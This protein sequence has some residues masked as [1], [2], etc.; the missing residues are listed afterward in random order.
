MAA[1]PARKRATYSDLLALPPNVVGQL[2]DGVV[3]AHPRPATPHA[4]ASSALGEELGPPFKRGRGGPG[5]WILLD[6]PEL[7]LGEDVVVPDLAGWR[8]ERLPEVKDVPALTLAPDWICEVLS[9]ST[10]G[11]DRVEKMEI[12]GAGGSFVRLARGPCRALARD[13]RARR[14]TLAA[15][16]RTSGRRQSPRASVRC[17]RARSRGALGAMTA[18]QCSDQ[19]APDTT[20]RAK[21][22]SPAASPHAS[23][24]A[25]EG[26]SQCAKPSSTPI[27]HGAP[28]C[29][30]AV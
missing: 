18:R 5:G 28:C 15:H 3:H 14:C 6:E 20:S 29:W 4:L 8:R 7:H 22:D 12:L 2:I 10:A 11:I 26:S 21:N 1:D 16:R 9:P 25:C 24:S 23:P 17:D 13:L 30:N 19:I 27:R